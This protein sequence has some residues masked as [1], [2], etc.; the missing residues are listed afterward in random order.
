MKLKNWKKHYGL[1]AK[2]IKNKRELREEWVLWDLKD[3]ESLL[4]PMY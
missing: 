2:E 4:R 3:F 1:I